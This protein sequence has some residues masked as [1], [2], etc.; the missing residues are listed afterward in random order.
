MDILVQ[1][2]REDLAKLARCGI[3]FTVLWQP[4]APPKIEPRT[5]RRG[6][7]KFLAGSR[8]RKLDRGVPL[9]QYDNVLVTELRRRGGR[10]VART[11]SELYHSL[12]K[13]VALT[14]VDIEILQSGHERW[15]E[16]M[17]WRRKKLCLDGVLR[18]D[19]PHGVWELAGVSEFLMS[20]IAVDH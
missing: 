9:A 4:L 8:R 19:S 16:S 7:R 17:Q 10:G 12:R 3:R 2:A 11:G 18:N 14:D 1:I 5:R 13:L 6:S 20:S 15:W